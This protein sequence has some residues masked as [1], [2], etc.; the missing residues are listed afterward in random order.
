MLS[1]CGECYPKT[2]PINQTNPTTNRTVFERVLFIHS[3]NL[4]SNPLFTIVNF[5]SRLCLSY[6]FYFNR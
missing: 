2:H 1:T 5:K 6:N 3:T 4:Q